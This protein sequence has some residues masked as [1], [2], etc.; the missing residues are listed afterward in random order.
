MLLKKS[1]RNWGLSERTWSQLG[2]P[3]LKELEHQYKD[4]SELYPFNKREFIISIIEKD[5]WMKRESFSL[6]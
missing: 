4:N 3:N 5:G 6:K 2:G 1:K